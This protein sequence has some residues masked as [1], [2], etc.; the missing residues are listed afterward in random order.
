MRTILMENIDIWHNLTFQFS[1]KNSSP[2]WT[3]EKTYQFQN[4]YIHCE[5]RILKSQIGNSKY[6]HLI[7]HGLHLHV[8]QHRQDRKR[9]P[10]NNY[11]DIDM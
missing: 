8:F 1:F 10:R 9:R 11:I 6:L 7:L 5:N 4:L 3:E 2:C